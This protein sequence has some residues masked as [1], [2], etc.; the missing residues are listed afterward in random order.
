MKLLSPNSYQKGS[1]VLHMLRRQLGDSIFKKSIR[2][3]YSTYAGKNA[4]TKDL[5]RIFETV[6]G[7]DLKQFFQQWL[8]TAENPILKISW[9]NIPI[10]KKVAITIEQV[11]NKIFELPLELSLVTGLRKPVIEKISISKKKETFLISTNESLT[12]LGVDNNTSLLAEFSVHE[13][14]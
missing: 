9:K 5:Q 1:W 13:E 3:Y 12:Q 4:D 7:K 11:Q 8:Y 14:K 6:S 2:L 10:E